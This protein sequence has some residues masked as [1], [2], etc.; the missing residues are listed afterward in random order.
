MN[1]R[2]VCPAQASPC[3]R[4]LTPSTCRWRF[5]A[6]RVDRPRD[7]PA[8]PPDFQPALRSLLEIRLE[9]HQEASGLAAG[10]HAMVESER[11]RQHTP[12]RT[13]GP[14]CAT[15]RW[16]IRPAPMI[17]TCGGTTTRLAN[18]PPI[19]PKFD[20]VMVAP[21]SSS[22]GIDR[23]AASARRRSSPAR[24]SCASRSATLRIHGHDQAA[25]GI[26]RDADVDARD[27]AP[28]SRCRNCTRR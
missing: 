2:L 4:A 23:A 9:R 3:P 12:H 8:A 13:A 19:I 27:Q 20:S 18:R 6:A 24:K 11:Q 16:A 28:F 14:R 25:F 1:D 15:A 5:A 10:H 22:G 17:A 21:R 26:D 7:G